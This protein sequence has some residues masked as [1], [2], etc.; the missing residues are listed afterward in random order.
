MCGVAFS[1]GSSFPGGTHRSE[2]SD[3]LI[4]S[5]PASRGAGTGG[6][7]G[8]EGGRA[9]PSRRR[10]APG[11]EPRIRGR[12]AAGG[13][14]WAPWSLPQTHRPGD[15]GESTGRRRPPEAPLYAPRFQTGVHVGS[16]DTLGSVYLDHFSRLKMVG[17]WGRRMGNWGPFPLTLC[18][19][20][21]IGPLVRAPDPCQM[22]NSL[23]PS[24]P[25]PPIHESLTSTH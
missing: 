6:L 14:G 20:W 18:K 2:G 12:L 17:G 11:S 16:A 10:R 24:E 1:R 15:P 25:R 4:P 23:F 22:L 5:F 21:T 19:S 3:P 13:A 8:S 7:P 9:D